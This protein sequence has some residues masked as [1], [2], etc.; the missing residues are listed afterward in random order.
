MATNIR[1]ALFIGLGGTGMTTLLHTKKTIYDNYGEIPPMIGFMAIDTDGGSYTKWID[2]RDGKR[3]Q[4][5][6]SEQLR[7]S[8]PNPTAIYSVGK[9]E[10]KYGWIAPGNENALTVLDRG[11]GQIRSNGRF[12]ITC[13]ENNV[14]TQLQAKINEI[15]NAKIIGNPN[16]AIL[17]SDVDIHII[18]SL[19]GG[20]GCGTFI[21]LAYLL[22]EISPDCKVSGYAVMGRVFKA[23]LSGSAVANVCIN[24]YGAIKDLDYLMSLTP[25]SKS[26]GIEW[27]SETKR[28][29]TRPFNAL[30]LIDNKNKLNDT[31][32]HVDTISEMISLA[33]V[34]AIGQLGATSASVADN[35]EKIIAQGLM[36]MAG[37]KAWVSGIGMSEIIYDGTRLAQIYANKAR[38]K[39]LGMMTNKLGSGDTI[40]NNWIDVE[41]IREN[42]G[43]DDII[44]YFSNRTSDRPFIDIDD[45][46][47]PEAEC[48]DYI[49]NGSQDSQESL[50]TKLDTLKNRISESLRKLIESNIKVEGGLS[51][52]IEIIDVLDEQFTLC[53]GEMQREIEDMKRSKSN[54]QE[55]LKF[56]QKDLID[57]ANSVFK[58]KKAEKIAN[59]CS[60][61][62]EVA[63]YQREIKRRDMAHLFYIWLIGEVNEYG[64]I[65]RNISDV[66]GQIR[67]RSIRNVESIT[68]GIVANS[69][70]QYN[71]AVNMVGDI[72]CLDSDIVFTDF[73]KKID[74][75]GGILSFNTHDTDWV[76]E[77][78]WD[79]TSQLPKAQDYVNKTVNEVLEKLS[80]DEL[81]EICKTMIRKAQPLIQT[82]NRGY[83]A[84]C[85]LFNGYFVGVEDKEKSVLGRDDHFKLLV[86]ESDANVEIVSAGLKDRVIIFHQ[87]GVLPA[88]AVSALDFFQQE[89]DEKEKWTPGT[90][91]WDY[92]LYQRFRTEH[93]DIWPKN[94]MEEADI[95]KMWIWS[96]LYGL[97]S[98]N[99]DG[100]FFIK[101]REL[102]GNIMEGYIVKMGRSRYDAYCFF[103]ENIPII[104][105]ELE[106]FIRDDNREDRLKQNR[107]LNKAKQEV[108]DGVYQ[109]PGH[110]SLNSLDFTNADN[111]RF[112][113]EEFDLLIKEM[114]Y[115]LTM[116][117]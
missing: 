32:T 38:V 3:I 50:D 35:V 11:A 98:K 57:C 66:I 18:F 43:R 67:S 71:L 56:S 28:V 87:Y 45:C 111:Q 30:Y 47:N 17:E 44:D 14:R 10:K 36:D 115:I 77:R 60:D 94:Q 86:P 2:A 69:L 39:V 41:R 113:P 7:I 103:A 51:L 1:R 101:S 20:T 72:E 55:A 58:I 93:F 99:G 83:K 21:N 65:M 112:Y 24:S 23:M 116:E 63:T 59:V 49:D 62:V 37:K 74:S 110:I 26:V 85:E 27:R 84:P 5:K 19:A 12:A 75:A 106:K 68:K 96:L 9:S 22:K 109:L 82:D 29:N 95:R 107:L 42:K 70:F 76:T 73:V 34:T 102:G 90:S 97:V 40:A 53:D 52:C 79:Y 54:A 78:I 114:E 31:Y 48:N 105:D 15:T 117:L 81:S 16:Y 8:V 92:L 108:L 46:K 89:Y 6:Q 88:F 25:N 91:H 13:N 4:L 64:R 33:L 104:K 100:E 61:T 80:R